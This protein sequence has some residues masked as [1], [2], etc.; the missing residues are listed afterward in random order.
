MPSNV[1]LPGTRSG[2][3]SSVKF[4]SKIVPV[5]RQVADKTALLP[6]TTPVERIFDGSFLK[7]EE[8]NYAKA[9]V[10]LLTEADCEVDGTGIAQASI[11]QARIFSTES[12]SSMYAQLSG[13]CAV[14]ED[15]DYKILV[16]APLIDDED[17]A[18]N[19]PVRVGWG[20]DGATLVL[21]GAG[22][23][24]WGV[25]RETGDANGWWTIQRK[26]GFVPAAPAP[27]EEP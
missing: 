22:E 25:V 4:I 14:V 12:S 9:R 13:G 15:N 8:S 7:Y 3:P 26:D 17:L 5:S 21:A 10:A 24:H 23:P 2:I 16:K 1:N 27:P 18:I 20:T 19:S 6:T 11:V